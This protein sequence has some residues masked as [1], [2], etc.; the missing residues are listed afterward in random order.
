MHYIDGFELSWVLYTC[1]ILVVLKGD[2]QISDLLGSS[3]GDLQIS[4]WS[5]LVKG[6]IQISD[7]IM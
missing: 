1:S 2:L 7:S 6:D 3:K 5:K 4:D